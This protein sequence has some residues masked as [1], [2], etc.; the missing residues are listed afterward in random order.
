MQMNKK[1]T[2]KKLKHFEDRYEKEAQLFRRIDK[3]TRN[4]SLRIIHGMV[5]IQDKIRSMDR[6]DL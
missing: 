5:G 4:E 6:L 3:D 2:K 1:Y